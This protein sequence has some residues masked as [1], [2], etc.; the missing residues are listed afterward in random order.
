MSID[1]TLLTN[2]TWDQIK[3]AATQAIMA[4]LI[5]GSRLVINGRDIMRVS[6]EDAKGIYLWA[7]Q[8]QDIEAGNDGN[9]L[10]RFGEAR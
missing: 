4:N 10:A 7:V 1:T 2:Y 8:M 9:A 3:T 6:V 5:G